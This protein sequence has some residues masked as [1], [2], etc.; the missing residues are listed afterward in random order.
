MNEGSQ[1]LSTLGQALLIVG[2]F[3]I[4]MLAFFVFGTM[5]WVRRQ[6]QGKIVGIFIEPNRQTTEELIP[7]DSSGKIRSKHGEK[8]KEYL[9]VPKKSFWS[10]WPKGFPVWMQETVPTLLYVRN[11]AEPFDPEDMKSVISS[12]TLRYITDPEM[13]RATWKDAASAIGVSPSNLKSPVMVMGI[14]LGGLI[15]VLGIFMFV[16]FQKLTELDSFVRSIA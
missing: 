5:L 2:G 11:N 16:I 14:I 15:I 8:D 3:T 9:L 13:L 10:K 4:G 6:V 12:R 7:I 1:I